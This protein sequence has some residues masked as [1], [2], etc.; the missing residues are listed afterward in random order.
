M[1]FLGN[2][3]VCNAGDPDLIPRSGSPLEKILATTHSSIL[4]LPWWLRQ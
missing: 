3:P 1:G 4:G 2:S